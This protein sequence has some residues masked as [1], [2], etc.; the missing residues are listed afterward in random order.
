M[1]HKSLEIAEEY[2]GKF[3]DQIGGVIKSA[4][5]LAT[6]TVATRV[7]GGTGAYLAKSSLATRMATSNNAIVRGIGDATRTVGAFAADNDFGIKS[8]R[9]GL[10]FDKTP[11]LKNN[12]KGAEKGYT[13]DIK[14]YQKTEEDAGKSLGEISSTLQLQRGRVLQGK[15]R[16]TGEKTQPGLIGKV[17]SRPLSSVYGVISGQKTTGAAIGS[18]FEQKWG[19]DYA[20]KSGGKIEKTGGDAVKKDLKK[21]AGEA[22]EEFG[23]N[24]LEK[25]YVDQQAIYNKSKKPIEDQ[26]SDLENEL[27]KFNDVNKSIDGITVDDSTYELKKSALQAGIAIRKKNIADLK[28]DLVNKK[29]AF[30]KKYT[31]VDSAFKSKNGVNLETAKKEG[32]IIEDKELTEK[33]KKKLDTED[34]PEEGKSSD[35]EKNEGKK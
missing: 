31:E 28:K 12:L 21:K 9:S 20:A 16:T 2:T 8:A 34:K 5:M 11:M 33:I 26:I 4:A 23:L 18:V 17:I 24:K 3:A 29:E 14:A 10:G 32:K 13:G 22:E 15:D 27:S 30:D 1:I 35:G 25:E 19:T 7:I 6:G